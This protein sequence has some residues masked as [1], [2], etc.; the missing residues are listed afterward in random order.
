M[1]S[2][3][4]SFKAN[5]LIV[6]LNG[7]I[8]TDDSLALKSI[9]KQ[10]QL[11]TAIDGKVFTTFADNLAFLLDCLKVGDRSHSKCIIFIL[12]EFDLFCAHSNQ[13]LIYNLFDVA[14]SAQAPI[15]V[16]GVTRRYDVI[17]LLEK[18]V[19]S[20]FSHR[21]IFLFNEINGVEDLMCRLVRQL[22]IQTNDPK[23]K[24]DN[25]I[26]WNKE[27]AG[28]TTNKQAKEAI[29]ALTNQSTSMALLN[30]L[31]FRILT[32]IP[33]ELGTKTQFTTNKLAPIVQRVVVDE[34][35]QIDSKVQLMCDLSILE[36]LLIISMKHYTDIYD[37]E[38]FNFEMI[39]TRLRKFQNSG[40]YSMGNYDREVLL[41]AFDVLKVCNISITYPIA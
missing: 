21:Q 8:H 2:T 24:K 37:G 12:E 13:T 1:L 36:I 41:K 15:C 29:E 32:L 22:H 39:L 31:T 14:Q 28:L 7:F 4:P 3:K 10:M 26:K 38:S 34:F 11:E 18:R 20:R 27:I 30:N 19:K 16:I 25:L 5:T 9:A 23:L 17:E 6:N 33:I 35:L 40:E